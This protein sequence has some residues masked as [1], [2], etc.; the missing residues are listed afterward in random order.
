MNIER[1]HGHTGTKHVDGGHVKR[2]RRREQRFHKPN[3]VSVHKLIDRETRRVRRR[4]HVGVTASMRNQGYHE[5]RNNARQIHDRSVKAILVSI[6]PN[7]KFSEH[8]R[9]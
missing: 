3:V 2:E 5:Q 6:Y 8:E 9:A 4:V 7:E 1:R